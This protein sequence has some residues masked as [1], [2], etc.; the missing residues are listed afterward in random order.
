MEAQK[1]N[2]LMEKL[3][4]VEALYRNPGSAGEREAAAHAIRR[5]QEKLLALQKYSQLTVKE[6]E[7]VVFTKR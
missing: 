7:F 4:R 6:Y 3:R 1:R 2:A 5:I